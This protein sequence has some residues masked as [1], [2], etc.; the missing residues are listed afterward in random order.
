M[1]LDE[2]AD[3]FI[4]KSEFVNLLKT[5]GEP[6]TEEEIRQLVSVACEKE[7]DMPHLIDIN[8]LA[9]ILLPE[10]VTENE[11]TKGTAG[12]VKRAKMTLH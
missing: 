6:L 4:E 3:G 2:D 7:S 8:R 9:K 10:I 12:E 11:L 5:C 1:E